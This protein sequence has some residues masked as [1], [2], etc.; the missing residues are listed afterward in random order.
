MSLLLMAL[1]W[2]ATVAAPKNVSVTPAPGWVK[3]LPVST[4]SNVNPKEVNDGYHFLLRSTQWEVAQQEVYYHNVYK[5][6][7]E[8]GVQN[9]SEL[10]ISFDPAYE[11]LALHKV[12]VWRNGA[13]I[14]K[15]DLKKV[16]TIQREQGMEQRIYDESL[17]SVLIL[18]DIRVGDV[19]E[20][21]CSVKG[22]NPVFEGKFFRGFNL[23]FYDPVDELHYYV[24]SPQERKINYKLYKTKQKQAIATING[25]TSYTWHVKNVTANATDND[26]PAWYDPYPGVYLSEFNSW[27]EVVE[28][29]LPLYELNEKLAKGL[30]AQVDSILTDYKTD[31][32]RLKATLRFVQDDVRY[33]GMEAGIGGFKPRSPSVVFKERFGDCKDKSLL[34]VTMLRQMGIKASPALVNTT[35]RG[36]V[37]EVLPSPYAFN[38]CIVQVDFWGKKYWYDPTIS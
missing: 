17:T 7:S 21:A 22:G 27:Q 9:N 34:L 31:E 8:E 6:V 33:L 12:V 11:R 25:K 18:D 10:K 5:I 20:Y 30:Q 3:Q 13:A 16:K 19:I 37:A 38:H 4:Q 24:V 15:L 29:A 26:I 32:D 28:W 2:Q 1:V 36:Q 23:Q 35:S 14:N